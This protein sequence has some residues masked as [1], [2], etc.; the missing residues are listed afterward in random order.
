[1]SKQQLAQETEIIE[2][3]KDTE[4]VF[5]TLPTCIRMDSSEKCLNYRL[6][7]TRIEGSRP[8]FEKTIRR[9]HLACLRNPVS[10]ISIEQVT[11]QL[12]NLDIKRGR[13]GAFLPLRNQS[14]QQF[15]FGNISEQW[16]Y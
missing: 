11:R 13:R 6:F 7:G 15:S 10:P 5:N 1:M 9:S 4:F 16:K 2:N 8:I 3:S 12:A 14:G